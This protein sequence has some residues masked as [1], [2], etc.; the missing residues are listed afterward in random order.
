MKDA[1]RTL[2]AIIGAFVLFTILSRISYHLALAFNLLSVVVLYFAVLRGEIYGAVTGM[3]CGLLHDS[4]SLG[5][6]GVMGIA[7]TIS[8]Y[9]AGH[10]A[11][12]I[13]IVQFSRRYAF[14]AVVLA[15]ELLVWG[16]LYGAVFSQTPHFGN[17]LLLLQ[18]LL[19]A[20]VAAGIFPLIGWINLRL[21]KRKSK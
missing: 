20:L 2:A 1:L 8:G 9:T 5:V 19:S 7:K 10:V 17:G 18:P 12:K 21:E 4:F 13:D 11:K 14:F 15:L 16:L 6:F 3:F